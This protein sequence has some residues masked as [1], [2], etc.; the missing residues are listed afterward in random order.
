MFDA[1]WKFKHM[2]TFHWVLEEHESIIEFYVPFNV[3]FFPFLA[4][5]ATEPIG[6]KK[7]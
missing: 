6:E 4:E 1:L 3:I 5:Q 2:F 7:L